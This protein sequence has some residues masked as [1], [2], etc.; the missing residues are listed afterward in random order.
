M[1]MTLSPQTKTLL[2]SLFPNLSSDMDQVNLS[3]IIQYLGNLPTAMDKSKNKHKTQL[4]T[5]LLQDI[6]LHCTN[7][8]LPKNSQAIK[9]NNE[10]SKVGFL[11]SMAVLI[12]IGCEGFDGIA[13]IL[14]LFALNPWI[15][16]AV[17]CG[18]AV[19]SILLNRLMKIL[20]EQKHYLEQQYSLIYDN[21]LILEEA[22]NSSQNQNP[23]EIS[24][25]IQFL[26]T[27]NQLVLR[28]MERL[29]A[30]KMHGARKAAQYGI[31]GFLC[32]I[33]FC[34][35]FFTGQAVAFFLASLAVTTAVTAW[36]VLIPALCIG[37]AAVSI[38]IY[39]EFPTIKNAVRHWF[40]FAEEEAPHSVTHEQI[41]KKLDVLKLRMDREKQRLDQATQIVA[42]EN[43]VATLKAGTGQQIL[44][45]GQQRLTTTQNST[46]PIAQPLARSL[47]SSTVRSGLYAVAKPAPRLRL[48]GGLLAE[49]AM[50]DSR[51]S[52]RPSD[53]L[54]SPKD[55]HDDNGEDVS[56]SDSLAVTF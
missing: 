30:S 14:G 31:M 50:F 24:E 4:L 6:K 29:N 40:G 3:D 47:S 26:R 28:D 36:P 19:C 10:S 44:L 20:G 7:A 41:S 23:N 25:V 54:N 43:E 35:G 17:A 39:Q 37:L 52:L 46:G 48:S 33:V 49:V 12:I 5:C 38:Y 55:H 56:I 8:L 27:A 22:L 15:T 32:G 53:S 45:R 11:I 42:L 18:V 9:P 34:G 13:S 2:H 1:L 51:A 16:F 21:A